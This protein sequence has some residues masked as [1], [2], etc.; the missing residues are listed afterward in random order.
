MV[1]IVFGVLLLVGAV[2]A[3]VV[4][5][6]TKAELVAMI[7]A[8]TLSIPELEQFRGVSD[9]LGARGGFRKISEVV[10]VAHPRPE[11]PLTAELSKTECVWYRYRI[12]RHYEEVERR[13][14]RRR[15]RKRTEKVAEHTSWEGYAVLDEHGN[16]IGVDPAGTAPDGVVQTVSRFEPHHGDAES[17]EVFGFRLP[18]GL[19]GPSSST[20]GFEYKEWIIPVGQRLFILGEVHDK[21]GP[22]V[23]GK[24]EGKGHFLISTRTEQEVRAARVQRHRFLAAGVIAGTLIGLGLLTAGIIA[25]V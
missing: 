20:I 25:A 15:V 10:G 19:L 22:L 14:G 8:D 12:D 16:T 23:I 4:M 13:D 17:I 2:A 3:F 24:P 18:G 9:E 5:R 21:I 6:R 11:G 7:S 1:S